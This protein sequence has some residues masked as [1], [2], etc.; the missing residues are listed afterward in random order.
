[1]IPSEVNLREW[2]EE[3]KRKGMLNIYL[4]KIISSE[5]FYIAHKDT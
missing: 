2:M 5:D 3:V 1:M 4:E